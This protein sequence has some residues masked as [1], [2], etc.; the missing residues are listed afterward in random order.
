MRSLVSRIAVTV[1]ERGAPSI[2]DS[3]PTMA[4]APRIGENALA[5]GRRATLSLEQAVVDPIAA[6]ARIAGE[7][8][9]LVGGERR[10]VA[11]WRKARDDQIVRKCRQQVVGCRGRRIW[12][13]GPRAK[14]SH[15]SATGGAAHA[16]A[17]NINADFNAQSPP[18]LSPGRAATTA[19]AISRTP[20]LDPAV[21]GPPPA[22]VVRGVRVVEV[23]MVADGGGRGRGGHDGHEAMRSRGQPPSRRP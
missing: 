9:H 10:R 2:I 14:S 13:G 23:V 16:R 3:S 15:N 20:D 12:H 18:G 1:A 11:P 22:A 21:T 4:P 8:Q 6:V 19:S 17:S 5:A 7:E